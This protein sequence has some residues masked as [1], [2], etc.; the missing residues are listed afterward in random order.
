MHQELLQPLQPPQPLQRQPLQLQLQ[1]QPLQRLPPHLPQQ[2]R[3]G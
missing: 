3:Q 2:Q 1:R